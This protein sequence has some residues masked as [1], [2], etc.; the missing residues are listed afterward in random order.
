MLPS[1]LAR[2]LFWL[3]V[4]AMG[5]DLGHASFLLPERLC[6]LPQET[7]VPLFTLVGV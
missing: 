2:M 7:N 1:F 4:S 3:V 5:D 6:A